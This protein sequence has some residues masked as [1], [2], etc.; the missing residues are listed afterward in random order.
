M[1]RHTER[2]RLARWRTIYEFYMYDGSLTTPPATEGVR[3]FVCTEKVQLSPAQVDSV[4]KLY[5]HNN[6]PVQPIYA[7]TVLTPR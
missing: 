6:R 4:K 1:G 3:W 5:F 7:R 2:Q